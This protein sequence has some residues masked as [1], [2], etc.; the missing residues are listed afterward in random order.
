MKDPKAGVARILKPNLDFEA[1]FEG[2]LAASVTD[3]LTEKIPFFEWADGKPP[4]SVRD[5]LAGKPG[6]D[7]NLMAYVPVPKGATI[8]LQIPYITPASE[9][10]GM[11]TYYRYWVAFRDMSL[12]YSNALVSLG[13]G[14]QSHIP[15]QALGR[16][17][18]SSG[19]PLERYIINAGLHSVGVHQPEPAPW[20]VQGG[21]LLAP[22]KFA[23]E[24][25]LH[26]EPLV[27][28]PTAVQ[29]NLIAAGVRGLHQQGVSDPGVN[30]N[31]NAAGGTWF[32][33]VAQ[34]DQ[35]LICVDRMITGGEGATPSTSANWSFAAAAAD[36]E[37]A[38]VY[39]RYDA[40]LMPTPFVGIYL[41]V[42]EH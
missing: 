12:A 6:F 19:T 24:L 31:S 38:D 27:P 8:Q 10:G 35:M 33:L 42:I 28:R 7:P 16:P 18:S 41:Y 9:G 26:P 40:A 36:R 2:T 34:G 20:F 5:P 15:Y 22:T 30:L 14:A 37:F 17:D 32:E 39:G 21:V 29:P 13:Q 11:P 3:E 25:A 4:L 23:N 1:L